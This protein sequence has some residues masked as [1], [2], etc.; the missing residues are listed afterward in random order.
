MRRKIFFGWLSL[1]LA[2]CATNGPAGL[3]AR[4]RDP[5]ALL[6]K[7]W[8]WLE[9]ITPVEKITAPNPDRYT[10][11]FASGGKLQARFDCNS[12]GGSYQI[13]QGKVSFGPLLSTRMACAPDSLDGTYMRDLQR[14]VSFFIEE[15]NLYLELP[16]DSGTMRF[17]PA[18]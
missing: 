1:W 8:Q 17:R 5:D 12:G 13:S 16:A 4:N 18:P 6:G 14:V 3:P 9:T 7:G 2:S 11:L 10:I 15:R